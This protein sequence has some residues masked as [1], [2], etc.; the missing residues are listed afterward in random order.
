MIENGGMQSA[1]SEF[2]IPIPVL[3]FYIRRDAF[4]GRAI[5]SQGIIKRKVRIAEWP[6]ERT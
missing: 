1:L 5:P 6:N 2:V 3:V 4:F